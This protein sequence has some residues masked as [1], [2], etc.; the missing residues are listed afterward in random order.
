MPPV[1]VCN[2]VWGGNRP[3]DTPFELPGV[4]GWLRSYPSDGGRGGDVHYLSVCGSGLLSRMSLADVA[5]HGE[6]VAKLSQSLHRM[7]RRHMNSPDQRILLSKL[8][9]EL[10]EGDGLFT[11]AVVVTYYAPSRSVSISYAG[12]PHAW[13]CRANESKWA[14]VQPAA[15]QEGSQLFDL[16]LSADPRTRFR[17]RTF[18][19]SPGDRLV[20]I[21]DGVLEAPSASG[22]QFGENRLRALLQDSMKQPPKDTVARLAGAVQGWSAKTG[23]DDV[24][25]LVADF[26]SGPR[27]P[28]IWTALKNRLVRPLAGLWTRPKPATPPA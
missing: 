12:H 14:R 17:R 25:I 1:L 9:T 22:E 10:S 13:Y 8:N 2:E 26:N 28:A 16:P 20:L 4:N 3:I 6:R 24:S 19:V 5:G 23:H 15:A 18:R 11:T 27:A 21:T 7:M